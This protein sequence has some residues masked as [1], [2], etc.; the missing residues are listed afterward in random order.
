MGLLFLA[1]LVSADTPS[2][3]AAKSYPVG[4][5]PVGAALGDF[6][7]DGKLDIAVANSG[8]SNVS[9]LL[10]NGDG[11]F[12]PAVNFD[13][14]VA[15]NGIAVEG[16]SIA[17]AD[18]NG[19]GK[20]DVAVFVLPN[21]EFS[22][23]SAVS[24]L[25]GNGDG[26]FQPPVM[27]TLS[28]QQTVAGVADVNGDKKPD[29]IVNLTDSNVNPAG[30]GVLLGNGEGTFQ[31]AKTVAGSSD[32]PLA[33]GDFNHDGKPD[34]AVNT[35]TAVQ[36]MYGNGDG[37]FSPGPQVIPAN[38]TPNRAWAIDLNGDGNADLIV[39][40]RSITS[41]G[42][43]SAT[44][45]YIG[46]FL[47]GGGGFGG[48]I[49][50]A[51]GSASSFEFGTLTDF[52]ITDIAG[53]DFDGDGRSDIANRADN[54]KFG[55]GGPGPTFALNLGDGAGK[56]SVVPMTDPGPLAAAFDLNGDQ[57]TD[58]VALNKPFNSIVV[59]VNS[60]PAFSMVAASTTLTAG[61]GEQVT[62]TVTV[63][64]VNGF[65]SSVQLSCQVVGPAPAPTCSLSPASIAAGTGTSTLTISVPA[66]QGGL[67]PTQMPRPPQL[68]FAMALLI[69]SVGFI[70]LQKRTGAGAKYSWRGF[71]AGSLLLVA[72]SYSSSGN[73]THQ[74]SPQ[75]YSVSVT[76][77]SDSLTKALQV[78]LTAP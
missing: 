71:L 14:G 58:L 60:T 75:Q 50:F 66:T 45:Q 7:G 30:V 78:S 33:V 20:L 70:P 47:S 36:I 77:A 74:Q 1:T 6:N 54:Y 40:S 16:F 28:V 52:L 25:F 29:L 67:F 31:A 27:T 13:A 46:A 5:F 2:F 43:D 48:E 26:T 9:I 4:T 35:L 76:G 22:V 15:V 56:F 42:P 55:G 11:T 37:S 64:A 53:G 61:A 65:S 72:S 19:D 59:L 10:G 44:T 23:P 68:F 18:F 8:S 41:N 3:Q 51:T 57:L 69:F 32:I 39:D 49:V 63:T 62:D 73:S 24:I 21:T 17:V 38:G 12:E 34:L